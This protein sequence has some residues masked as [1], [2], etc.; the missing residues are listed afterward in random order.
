[1]NTPPRCS[2]SSC[3]KVIRPDHWM[4]TGHW[5]Q[6]PLALRDQI[7]AAR[8]LYRTDR[9]QA[10]RNLM[11]LHGEAVRAVVGANGGR[12]GRGTR[13]GRARTASKAAEGGAL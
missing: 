6:I 4:C 13:G 2:V 7:Q 10:I 5:K 12:R 11:Q 1:M 8:D 9:K 3:G